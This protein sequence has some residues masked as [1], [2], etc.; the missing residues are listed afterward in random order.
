MTCVQFSAYQDPKFVSLNQL[1]SNKYLVL[2]AEARNLK[3][4]ELMVHGNQNESEVLSWLLNTS[5]SEQNPSDRNW[6]LGTSIFRSNLGQKR[7]INN[8]QLHPDAYGTV[9]SMF[10]FNNGN[11]QNTI[12][13]LRLIDKINTDTTGKQTIYYKETRASL[14]ALFKDNYTFIDKKFVRLTP[15]NGICQ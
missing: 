14:S 12:V 8:N 2:G 7:D 6:C 10:V 13:I 4:K 1:S 3:I 5:S 15:V 11:P 9:A